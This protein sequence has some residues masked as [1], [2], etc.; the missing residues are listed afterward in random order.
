MTNPTQT[1]KVKGPIRFE[2]IIPVLIIVACTYGYFFL[3]FDNHVRSLIEL[4]GY[5]A[6]GAEVNVAKVETSFLRGTLRIQGIEITDATQPKKN[7][8]KLGDIRFGVLWDGLLRARIIVEEMAVEQIEVGSVRNKPGKVKT[9]EPP[10]V[11]SDE[12]SVLEEKAKEIKDKA[13]QKTQEQ[14]SENVLGDIAGILSGTSTTQDKGA[15][16]EGALASKAKLKEF[17]TTVATKQKEWAEKV[18]TLPSSQEIQS[19]GDKLGKV[20]TQNFSSPQEALDSIKAIEQIVKEFDEKVKKAQATG[21]DL[22]SDMKNLDT[23]LKEIDALIKKD[24][25]DLEKRFKIPKIDAQSLTK[26]LLLPY[27]QPYLD[28]AKYYKTL[29]D[30]YVPPN[31]MKKKD[32]ST[33][34][35]DIKPHPRAKGITYE[36]GKKNSYPMFWIKKIA[37]SSKPTAALAA[38]MSGQITDI[39]SNQ[40][41]IGKPTVI[42]FAGDFPDLKILDINSNITINT[43]GDDSK[44]NGLFAIGSMPIEEKALASSEDATVILKSG[45]SKLKSTFELVGLR[46][47]QLDID[48]NISNVAFESSSKNPDL[49]QILKNVFSAIPNLTF[50][51]NARGRFPELTLSINSNLGPELEKGFKAQIDKKIE[52][53]R[54]KLTDD[55]QQSVGA[56]RAKIEAEIN[57]IKSTAEVEIKKITDQINKE[58]SKGEAKTNQAKKDTENQTKGKAEDAAKKA[59]EDLKKK[60]GF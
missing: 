2:A 20:K 26:A 15:S 6:V 36:F 5:H 28:R 4:A 34:D 52:A 24:I 58:K 25:A 47:Y 41:L 49:G 1:P 57:K 14:Y 3:F 17:E 18:K 8:I 13:L 48:N 46:N 11:E 33:K 31:L 9:P 7:L 12:P 59:A 35:E 22:N 32:K 27:V 43:M 44:I 55:V 30:K 39:T 40:S 19:L 38:K 16:L 51:L 37:I 53:L 21:N 10:S 60:L 29:A 54:K 56:E 50:D 45:Q 23:G 42:Q